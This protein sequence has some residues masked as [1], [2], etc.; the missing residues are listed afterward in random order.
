[1]YVR[2]FRAVSDRPS[3]SKYNRDS[4]TCVWTP[5]PHLSGHAEVAGLASERAFKRAFVSPAF[6]FSSF[7]HEAP[8]LNNNGQQD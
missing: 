2:C 6:S 1:M 4:H 3:G 5:T 8:D 7:R